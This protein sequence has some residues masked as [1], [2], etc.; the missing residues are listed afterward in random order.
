VTYFNNRIRVSY[1]TNL[2]KGR[3]EMALPVNFEHES[4]GSIF[5]IF[6]GFKKARLRYAFF[7]SRGCSI[8]YRAEIRL[9]ENILCSK[10]ISEKEPTL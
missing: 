9:Y 5:I 6:G 3:V 8:C 1:V 7:S 10:N 2:H 4:F